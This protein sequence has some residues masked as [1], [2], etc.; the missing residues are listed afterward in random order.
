[1][2]DRKFKVLAPGIV[3]LEQKPRDFLYVFSFNEDDC[4]K[5]VDVYTRSWITNKTVWSHYS[6]WNNVSTFLSLQLM[7]RWLQGHIE[8]SPETLNW[9]TCLDFDKEI[10]QDWKN[11][12]KIVL[13]NLQKEI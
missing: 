6:E 10:D 8:I 11:F 3:H 1:M 7:W 12:K 5:E 13:E 4:I 2:E 9:S